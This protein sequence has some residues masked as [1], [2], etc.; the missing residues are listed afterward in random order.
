MAK[1]R[2]ISVSDPS[3]SIVVHHEDGTALI[4][5]NNNIFHPLESAQNVS[6]TQLRVLEI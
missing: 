3:N 5:N 4:K 6:E 2:T 1:R